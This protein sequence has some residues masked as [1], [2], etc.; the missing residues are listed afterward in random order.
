MD[1]F[2]GA[3]IVDSIL[4]LSPAFPVPFPTRGMHPTFFSFILC[5]LSSNPSIK[6]NKSHVAQVEWVRFFPLL[7]DLVMASG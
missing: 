7:E 2:P 4:F 1:S 6:G 3:L 5:P